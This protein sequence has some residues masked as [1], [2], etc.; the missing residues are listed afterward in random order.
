MDADGQKI[1]FS[2]ETGAVV[3]MTSASGRVLLAE[4]YFRNVSNTY[5]HE[6]SLVS[7]YSA[8]EGLMRTRTGADGELVMEWYAPAAVTVLADGTYEVTGNLIK[9]PPSCPRKKTACG[10]PSSRASSA[11]CRPT[12]SPVRKNP[13]ESASPKARGRHHH[14]HH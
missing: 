11:D 9:P 6:G 12:P 3:G 2:A 10:P 7:S 14:P 8:A 13:A 5:D 4:D 1:R